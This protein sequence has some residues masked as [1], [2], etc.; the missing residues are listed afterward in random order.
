MLTPQVA[1]Y[2]GLGIFLQPKKEEIYFEHSGWDEGFCSLIIGHPT[3]GYGAAILI[4]ANQPDLIDELIAGL[5][6]AYQWE[7][8]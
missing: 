5:G 8:F 6:K 4:N 3:N 1:P 7:G 2:V